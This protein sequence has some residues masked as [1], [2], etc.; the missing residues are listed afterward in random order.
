[1][2]LISAGGRAQ[3]A[4]AAGRCS[5]HAEGERHIRF[6]HYHTPRPGR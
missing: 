4:E 1:M 6:N 5:E 2:Y 3:E